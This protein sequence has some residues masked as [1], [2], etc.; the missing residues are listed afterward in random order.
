VVG[1]VAGE[2]LLQLADLA[3]HP[4]PSQLRQH[5]GVTLPGDQRGHHLP[6]GDP[7]D[8]T[9]H[10]RQLDLGVLK[11]LLGPLLLRGAGLDQITPIPGDVAQPPDLRRGHET[12]ANHLPLGDLAQPHRVQLVGLGPARQVLDIAGVDQPRVE[13]VRLQQVIRRFPVF[14]GGL[15]DHPGHAQ[16]GQ[17][18]GQPQQRAGHRRIARHLLQ[19]PTRPALVWH[20]HATHQLGLADVQRRDPRDDLLDLLVFLEH[21]RLPTRRDVEQLDGR[22]QG[23]HGIG[24]I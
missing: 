9:G 23:P 22:P 18:V 8:V 1:E 12:R 15:H 10:H 14:R 17:P 6:P 24:G 4:P 21:F 13:S 2:R 11:Q 5:L 3:A 16:L 7:E 19:P 20:P